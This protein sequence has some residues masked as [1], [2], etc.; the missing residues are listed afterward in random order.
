LGI[1][2]YKTILINSLFISL[3]LG[4]EINYQSIKYKVDDAASLAINK[5]ISTSHLK[6]YLPSIP[7][8]YIMR[9]INGTLVRLN[10]SSKGWEYF[11]AKKHEKINPLTYDFWLRE[12]VKFQ[13]GTLFDA[14]SVIENFKFFKK[15]AFTYTDIHHKL[16]F[17]EKLAKYKIRI[18][19]NK[20]YGMLLNDLARINLYTSKYLKKYA[21]KNNIVGDNTKAPG[22]YGSGPYILTSGYATGLKQSEKIILKA[23]PYYFEKG[24]PYIQ[25]ITIFTKLPIEDVI[26]MISEEEGKLDIA[27]IPMDKKTE[28][29][30]STYAKLIST[31][32]SFNLSIHMN[33]INP[34]SKLQNIEIR[35]ALNQALDQQKLIKFA[36]KNEGTMS[37]FLLSS[38]SFYAKGISQEYIKTPKVFFPEVKLKKLLNGLHLKVITQDRF[39][40]LWKGIEYQLNS[41]GVVLDYDITT[42]ETYVLNKLLTNRKN[43]YDWDLLIWGNGDWYGHPWTAFFTLYT[44]NQWSAIKTDIVLDKKIEKF[45]EID[46]NSSEF[47]LAVN[48][49]LEYTYQKAYMLSIPSPNILLAMNK[50]VSFIPSS[51][52]ILR[53]WE[54]KVTPYHWSVRG[55]KKLPKERQMYIFPKRINYD[56]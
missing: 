11:L 54:A 42:D 18:H 3:I 44:K 23:N 9:L 53:L 17:V 8:S 38:N 7:Y 26:Y 2:L 56:E 34:L 4:N 43:A 30:N 48:D 15:G 41:Y 27:V 32:S 51:V 10:S 46:M 35:E 21:W 29:V 49:I 20:P 55:D 5:N 12:D 50:E 39:L 1:N 19:L 31:E 36:Y 22:P 25:T 40:S 24:K 14:D 28:I 52:A 37:P 6:I 16:K 47:Q 45:F 33:L 13:D